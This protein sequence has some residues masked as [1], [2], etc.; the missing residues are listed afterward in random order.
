M[1]NISLFEYSNTGLGEPLASRMRPTTLE[2]FYGQK[3]ILGENKLLYR[4]IKANKLKSVIF[5]G[6]TG[7]GKTT[8]AKI[9]ANSINGTNSQTF[10][11]INATTSG[12]KDIKEI[13]EEASKTKMYSGVQTIL[14]IDEI[15]R[16][17]KSQQDTLLPHIESGLIILIGATTENPYFEINNAIISRSTIFSL[18]PLDS[19]DIRAIINRALKDETKGYGNLKVKMSAQAKEF[20][21]DICN[22]D[23]RVALNALELA[24]LTTNESENGEI[25][26]TSD[27][28]SDCIQ[29]RVLS[30]D[31]NGD[32]HYDVISAFIKS[33]RGSDPDAGLYYL[34]KML[35][36]GE[37]PMFI[38]RRLVISAS[39]D[40]GNANPQALT[41]A[42][43]AMQAV[44]F[45][46]M[47]EARIV[48]A[49]AVT[50][51]ATSPKSNASYNGI[52]S[53]IEDVR[54]IKIK[55][56]PTHL[57][58]AHYKGAQ[59]LGHGLGYKYPHVYPNNYVEQQYL[60]DE[61]VG[62]KYYYP[63]ENGQELRIKQYAES[64]RGKNE[65]L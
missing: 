38:A 1:D 22:G 43:S 5:Y 36:S 9:I 34:A 42:V 6:N 58:D 61:L 37:D 16:F 24:V 35:E 25:V 51:I 40:V 63:T 55:S 2:E 29:K 19:D 46:G 27:I 32:N 7:T 26:L 39:E 44:H 62:Q 15:H 21:S 23:A 54:N 56:L 12:I 64:I 48:L 53:A 49:Q 14:F 47:P 18:K 13:V 59:K 52:A 8:L 3:H 57:K 10:K 28:I 17:N 31:K 65:K 11:K 33:L 45:V 50:Y 41:L 20:L 30:Y 4:M 60:P